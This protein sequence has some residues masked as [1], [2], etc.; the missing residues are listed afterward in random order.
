MFYR[1]RRAAL[2]PLIGWLLIGPLAAEEKPAADELLARGIARLASVFDAHPVETT[3]F[4]TTLEF[5]RGEGLPKAVQGLQ[6][7]LSIATPDRLQISTVI[8]KERVTFGRVGQELWVWQPGKKFAV[9]GV[10]G[11]PRFKA[12]PESIDDTELAPLGIKIDHDLIARLPRM[13]RAELGERVTIDGEP[14]QYVTAQ[15][16]PEARESLRLP[17]MELTMALRESDSIPAR[18]GYKSGATVVELALHQPRIGPAASDEAWQLP[19]TPDT[20]VERVAISHLS[21]F[22]AAAVSALDSKT[23]LPGPAKG[24]RQLIGVHGAGRL[25]LHDGTR[26]LFVKGTPEEIGEQHGTLLKEEIR[27][28]VKRVVYGVGVG[29]SFGKGRWFFGE[30][31]GCVQRL[32]PFID[33]RTVR[34]MDSIA[35][36]VGYHPQEIRLANFFPEM[37]HC[38]GFALLGEATEGKRIYH[39]RILDYM[40]GIGL[41]K[42]AVVTVY[43]PDEGHA[44][45]NVGYAGFTGS[46]TAMNDQHLSIGEMGGRGEG[47]WDG[48]PM[49]QLVREV[50]E[51][52]E[53]LEE[54]VEIMRRGPRTCEYYYVIADGRAHTAVGI[55]ATPEI[56]EVVHPGEGHPQL[57]SP[58]K[59]TVLL[60]AGDRYRELVR[61]VQAGYGKF[62][63]NA[64]RELMT[65]PVCMNSNIHSV[66]FAP[67]TLDFWV[68]NSDG[69]TPASHT[70]Y[71]K[72]NLR[73]L[74]SGPPAVAGTGE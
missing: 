65:R 58:I 47:N 35:K 11:V 62:D 29:S 14:C 7:Q 74:L 25:E 24:E 31:E 69:E 23:E 33:P 64:A 52:A 27:D 39:G 44:W 16:L 45:V 46:V 63:A 37:F 50:M 57:D 41:E 38:S 67:D 34:E 49:A 10:A 30:I 32:S 61:R 70:R 12:D 26:V 8:G 60:S 3:E 42:N 1:M 36:T 55:K 43:Q 21:K 59:D 66:L 19:A 18:I 71:T 53:T 68:A 54:A 15:P 48:K 2:V 73:E 5:V 9:R 17:E 51:K 28:L 6:V 56:F 40:K 20:H 22:V 72:Y 13:F 4:R